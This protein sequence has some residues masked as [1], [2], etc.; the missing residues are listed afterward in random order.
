MNNHCEAKEDSTAEKIT[1]IK[2]HDIKRMEGHEN[3]EIDLMPQ[4]RP[5]SR[6]FGESP[7]LDELAQAQNV[8]PMDNVRALFG[9]WPGEA[10]DGFEAAIDELRRS[11][12]GDCVRR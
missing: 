11:N 3:E 1:G 6:D 7:T 9:T 10:D 12:T 2:I 8:V 4:G 5:I